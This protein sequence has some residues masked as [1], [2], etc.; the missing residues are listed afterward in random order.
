MPLTALA[1]VAILLAAAVAPAANAATKPGAKCTKAGVTVHVGN[2][3][4]RCVKKGGKLVWVKVSSEGAS[5]ENS[6][7]I[8]SNAS[9]PKV[10]QNWGLA[11][12]P[13]DAAT[14]KAGVMQIAGVTPP[15]FSNPADTALYSRIVGLYGDVVQGIL[16]PQMAF[17]APLGTPVISMLDGTVCDLPQLYSNDYSVRVAPKGM[18]CMT[19]GAPI[20][21]EHEHLISPL[22]KVG[23]KVRAGQRL[24][25][26]S[27]YN[28][29][30][31]AKGMGMI[32]TGV[33]FAKAGSNVPWHACLANY[34]APSKKSSMTNVLTSIENGWIAVRNDP[35][36]YSLAAQNPIGCLTQDDITDSNTGVK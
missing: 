28:S 36:L 24:G 16:E 21:F 30:W 20:L 1:A 10:I 22:V 11:L 12:E 33:F 29:D 8:T 7:S 15:T 5:G 32:E 25:T 34:L 35:G 4:L 27:D 14:G 18:A 19:G 13:Y 17:I 2:S 31:K 9:I 26:V 23:D 3:D 6:S